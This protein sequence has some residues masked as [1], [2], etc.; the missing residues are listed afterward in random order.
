MTKS[1]ERIEEEIDGIRERMRTRMDS[2]AKE[3]S[4]RAIA[5]RMTGK[6]DP[7]TTEIIDW[8]VS[9]ATSNPIAT[10]L[11]AAGLVGFATQTN[12]RTRVASRRQLDDGARRVR[13]YASSARDAVRGYAHD[14]ADIAVEKADDALHYARETGDNAGRAISRGAHDA[15]LA[16]RR[17]AER[18]REVGRE[19]TEWVRRNPTATG[20]FALALG[21][22]AASVFA[23][24]RK[25]DVVL[26]ALGYDEPAP[27]P[28]SGTKRKPSTAKTAGASSGAAKSKAK[29]KPAAGKKAAASKSST[30]TQKRK[31]AASGAKATAAKA[32]ATRATKG[33]SKAATKP[34]AP[35]T[36]TSPAAVT[37][38]S[39]PG[40]DTAVH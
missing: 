37:T 5:A 25:D 40:S 28:K 24:R 16:A 26:H 36:T 39:A 31:A 11:V 21:A 9:K 18:S 22:A 14:A 35:A 27:A 2:A 12:E 13:G 29:A 38:T 7:S 33:P 8:A 32:R 30:A 15:E 1:S 4:P 19:G 23:A 10:A 20:L 3:F 6:Q 17:A 34:A